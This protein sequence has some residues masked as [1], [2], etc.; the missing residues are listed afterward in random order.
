MK[1]KNEVMP[2]E[3]PESGMANLV[4]CGVVDMGT[5]PS[6]QFKPRREVAI[7]FETVDQTRSEGDYAGQPFRLRITCTRTMAP[8]G[9][10]VKWIEQWR[11]KAF[12]DAEHEAHKHEGYDLGKM[13]GAQAVGNLVQNA[14]GYTNIT[15]LAKAPKGTPKVEPTVRWY[16]DLDEYDPHDWSQLPEYLQKKIAE[17]PEYKEAAKPK[18]PA[19]PALML[20]AATSADVTGDGPWDGNIDDSDEVPF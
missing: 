5:Q 1:I 11:G 8:K 15:T 14:K 20:T 16:L 13:I 18:R 10:L 4:C 12:T 2:S 3:Q 19:T 7:M 9:G 17:S 6:Q